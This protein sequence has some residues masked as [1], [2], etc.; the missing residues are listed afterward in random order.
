[1]TALS[2]NRETDRK[3]GALISVPV[4]ASKVIYKGAMCKK[5]SSGYLVPAADAAGLQ[6]QTY[7]A[8]EK[9]DNSSGADGAVKCRVYRKGI[10]LFAATSITQAM[11]GKRMFVVDDQTFDDAAGTN[12]IVAGRLVEFVSTTS[13]W[14]DIEQ[15][16]PYVGILTAD[17]DATYGQPE[18][19][20]INE[21]KAALNA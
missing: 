5:N 9:V 21:I 10:F 4:A 15:S 2:A 13:G 17:A 14:I 19:D 3:D 12:G 8:Y 20:L 6:G 1:M 11:V 16:L 7:V 18:A